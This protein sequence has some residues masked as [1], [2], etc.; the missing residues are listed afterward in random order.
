LWHGALMLPPDDAPTFAMTDKNTRRPTKWTKDCAEEQAK[1]L[2]RTD[3]LK[4]HTDALALRTHPFSKAEHDELDEHLRLH[5][6]DLA[7]FRRRCFG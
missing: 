2:R 3:E 6:L 7:S 5:R 4:A 1:L